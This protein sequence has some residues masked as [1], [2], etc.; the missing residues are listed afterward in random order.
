MV[1]LFFFYGSREIAHRTNQRSTRVYISP[2][3]WQAPVPPN[4]MKFGIRGQLTDIITCV[5]SISSGVTEFWHP[6]IAIS[7][8]LAVS[9][10]QRCTH[11]YRATLW[12]VHVCWLFWFSCQ[13]LPSDSIERLLWW[14]LYVV[15]AITSTKPRSKSLLAC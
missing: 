8:W 4:S 3:C 13:Y 11:S 5:F 14:R 7:H 9:P 1:E 15:G 6:K 10:L 12:Y 2:Y